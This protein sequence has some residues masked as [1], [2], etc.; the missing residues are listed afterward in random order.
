MIERWGRTTVARITARIPSIGLLALACV[1]PPA[2]PAYAVDGT[3]HS[4][5]VVEIDP[6]RGV[7][8]IDE[9]GPGRGEAATII[10]RA[11]S[12]T[13]A[14]RFRSFIRVDVMGG[15]AGDFI[16]VALDAE[17]VSIGD[18]VTAECVLTRGRLIAT[19]VTLA[20]TVLGPS[21]PGAHRP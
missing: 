20:E 7:L 19:R 11:I 1:L 12:L 2:L 6:Q 10:R 4:G 21:S 17:D 13:A 14:T 18:F 16:E 8:V 9:T 5:T 15:F 3:R